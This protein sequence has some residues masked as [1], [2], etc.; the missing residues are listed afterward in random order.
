MPAHRDREWQVG[1]EPSQTLTTSEAATTFGTPTRPDTLA[2]RR[3]FLSAG[4]RPV[5]CT[6]CGTTVL[7]KKNSRKHTSIQ[8]T[9]DAASSCAVYAEHVAA[10]GNSALLDTCERLSES[11]EGAARAGVLEVPDGG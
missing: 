11:I 4:L 3:E 7:V 2:D 5:R 10:G 9:T 8:W 6:S 1:L